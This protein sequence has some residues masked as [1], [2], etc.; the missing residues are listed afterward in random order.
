[1]DATLLAA[2][3]EAAS[4]PAGMM[5]RVEGE[6]LPVAGVLAF[7]LRVAQGT[8]ELALLADATVQ[9]PWSGSAPG[10][11]SQQLVLYYFDAK[12]GALVPRGTLDLS[13]A[14]NLRATIDRLGHWLIGSHGAPAHCARAEVHSEGTPLPRAGIVLTRTGAFS[15]ARV[16]ADASG[17]G[18]ALM[19]LGGELHARALGKVG[20]QLIS[21][22]GSVASSAAPA[23]CDAAC[24]PALLQ[25]VP[26]SLG[27]VTGQLSIPWLGTYDAQAS[28]YDALGTRSVAIPANGAFCVEVRAGAEITLSSDPTMTC[29]NGGVLTA[30]APAVI[31]GSCGDAQLEQCSSFTGDDDC[32]GTVDEGCSCG[33]ADCTWNASIDRCCAADGHCGE[34][35]TFTGECVGLESFGI[36]IGCPSVDVPVDEGGT[37]L[38]TGCCRSNGECG[39]MWGTRGCVAAADVSK[40]WGPSVTLS[41]I[42]CMP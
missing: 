4:V 5:A 32:D 12:E 41:N 17:S 38:A 3:E 18:C 20:E 6:L 42:A 14:L 40:V 2:P 27:C 22:D 35:A 31:A 37:T 23:V 8:T 1:V 9:I 16:E 36:P 39:L 30:S 15:A 28:V 19:P 11:D 13:E 26:L 24:A 10:I 25:G 21:A 34:R 33:G 29:T 7:E